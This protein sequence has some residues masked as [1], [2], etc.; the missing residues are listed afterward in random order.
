M[1][2]M[3]N[4]I[5][6]WQDWKL[7]GYYIKTKHVTK[8]PCRNPQKKK[9]KWYGYAFGF[10]SLG[11]RLGMHLV[12]KASVAC[13]GW[14]GPWRILCRIAFGVSVCASYLFSEGATNV[15]GVCN[16]GEA[17]TSSKKKRVTKKPCKNFEK[18]NKTCYRDALGFISLGS[19]LVNL[20][21]IKGS[22]A[23]RGWV[24]PWRI[25]CR[26]AFS[27]IGCASYLCS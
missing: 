7:A 8:V 15:C 20:L 18:K 26:I 23:C 21:V 3:S 2:R 17:G 27:V 11:S 16:D 19:R 12:I 4:D 6:N 1:T 22:D 14:V 9:K 24:G 13:R 10:I 5:S 25:L